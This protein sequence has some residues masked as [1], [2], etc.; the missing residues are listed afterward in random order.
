MQEIIG[1]WEA[2]GQLLKALFIKYALR[3]VNIGNSRVTEF[4]GPVVQNH[5]CSAG[6]AEE[7]I[8]HAM[9]QQP[10]TTP[11]ALRVQGCGFAHAL[12]VKMYIDINI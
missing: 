5:P 11:P 4:P 7:E 3:T 12:L 10:K 8:P 2:H 9:Q 1:I 6:E